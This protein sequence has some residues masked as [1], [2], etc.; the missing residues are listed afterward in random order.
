MPGGLSSD[1]SESPATASKRPCPSADS[2]GTSAKRVSSWVPEK[3]RAIAGPNQVLLD[4][5]REAKLALQQRVKE[6]ERQRRLQSTTAQDNERLQRLL[7]EAQENLRT[8]TERLESSALDMRTTIASREQELQQV[9]D[10]I[11]QLE[12]TAAILHRDKG[13]LLDQVKLALAEKEEAVRQL[14]E[15][16][17]AQRDGP[18]HEDELASLRQ[19]KETEKERLEALIAQLRAERDVFRREKM[20]C[21]TEIQTLRNAN[22]SNS[23]QNGQV[24][25]QPTGSS[26]DVPLDISQI[27][28]QVMEKFL[29][30]QERQTSNG[31]RT[32]GRST[33]PGS[34]ARILEVK[35]KAL[36][37]LDADKEAA[38]KGLLHETFCSATGATAINSFERYDPVDHDTVNNFADGK[39]PGPEG[40]NRFRLY[41]GDAWRTASWNRVVISHMIPL[42][43]AGKARKNIGGSSMTNDGI[44]ACIWGYISQ[45]RNSW[46]AY[47]PRV[48]SSGSR[49]ETQAEAITRAK[50]SAAKRISSVR[51]NNRKNNVGSCYLFVYILTE[52]LQQKF[53][54]RHEAVVKLLHHAPNPMD[55]AKWQMVKNVLDNVE[56]DAMSSDNTDTEENPATPNRLDTPAQLL[57]TVP[58]YRRRIISDL[59]D[60]LDASHKD[61]VVKEARKAGTRYMP[62]PTRLR[63]RTGVKSERTVAR[64]LPGGLYHRNFLKRLTPREREAV[65]VKEG[66]VP[67]FDRWMANR[68][69]ADSD[70]D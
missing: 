14:R 38:W 49:Y 59:F 13:I 52:G 34:A 35:R 30:S 69:D 45:A 19:D 60:D 53:N 29:A 3:V 54:D 27:I 10:E 40:A 24:N 5:E 47:Q 31:T 26:S 9:Q 21:E 63:V 39:G 55:K 6:L 56:A 23:A 70:S 11:E 4:E 57:I 15:S 25:G 48:H 16:H 50:A 18:S 22:R 42:V 46:K 7:S 2:S 58:H 28:D 20:E 8:N 68:V 12:V 61:F 67:F 66:E 65:A 37:A 1:D 44:E 36:G 33:K 62:K 51:Q 41:F 17:S 64:H 32:K 43:H